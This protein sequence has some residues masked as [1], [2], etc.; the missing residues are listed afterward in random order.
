MWLRQTVV[1]WKYRKFSISAEMQ[2]SVAAAHGIA[3]NFAAV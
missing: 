2:P 3:A 1:V